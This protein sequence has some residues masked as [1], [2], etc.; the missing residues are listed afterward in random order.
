MGEKVVNK[1]EYRLVQI[2]GKITWRIEELWDGG[3]VREPFGNKD[4]AIR[5][6]EDIARAEGFID[7]LVLQEV[8]GEE[9][10]SK[11]SFERDSSG[12]WHCK[13]ACAIR[14]DKKEIVFS[15]GMEFT[16]GV[17]YMSVD[18]AKWLDEN[19]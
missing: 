5:R 10:L 3:V 1:K 14:M 19:F 7:D 2:E 17:P 6:E 18:V 13:E 16:R 11:D 9:K 4:A 12:T 15:S 8:V